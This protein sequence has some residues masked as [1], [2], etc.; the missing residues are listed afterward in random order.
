MEDKWTLDE[1]IDE[2]KEQEIF[3]KTDYY[4][5]FYDNLIK[6]KKLLT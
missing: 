3:W 6:K 5:E 4:K 1:L 2:D